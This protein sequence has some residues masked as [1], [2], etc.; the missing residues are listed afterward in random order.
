MN[1]CLNNQERLQHHSKKFLA[2]K[3]NNFI[4]LRVFSFKLSKMNRAQLSLSRDEC[5]R[6]QTLAE[7]GRSQRYIATALGVNQS[8]I[9]R[10]LKRLRETGDHSRRPG[11]GPTR[12]T[13][14]L[15]DRFL[16]LQTL[17]QRFLTTRTLQR[18]ILNVHNVNLSIETV[19]RRLREVNLRP[20]RPATGPKLSLE[21]RRNRL[22]YAQEHIGWLEDDWACTLFTDESR[23]CLE[24][25]DQRIRVFR[26]VNE[27]YAQCNFETTSPFGGGSVMV[28]GGISLNGRTDLVIF[29]RRNLNAQRYIED[30]L[31][32][33]VLPFAENMGDRFVLMQ[34]N[35][36]PHTARIVSEYLQNSAI[37]VMRWPSRSP[38][39]NPIEHLWDIMGRRLRLLNPAPETLEAL[40][41][42]LREIW[43]GIDQD[44]IRRLIE[45][46]GRRCGAVIQARG[47]NTRY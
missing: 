5:V 4:I 45:S 28:W 9:S 11:Q 20:R 44:Q 27:R 23:F 29:I 8:T 13:T 19:R 24:S 26:R 46:M 41:E 22:T 33:H 43:N 7:E 38:D 18:S 12:K 47:G 40:A 32:P 37:N 21:H 1:Y 6:V 3:I 25:S 34:D 42:A 16:V 39:L 10:V 35:A 2:T 31:E 17:R 30:V 14:R 15:H 36:R